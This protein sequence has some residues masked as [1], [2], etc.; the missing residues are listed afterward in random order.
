[1]RVGF[2]INNARRNFSLFI[3]V[4]P[5]FSLVH[6]DR[7]NTPGGGGFLELGLMAYTTRYRA[8]RY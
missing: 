6:G 4:R 7:G 2:E 8:D 3:A 1:M 5:F